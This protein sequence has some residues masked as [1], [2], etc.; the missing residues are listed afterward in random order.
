M[1]YP[2]THNQTFL[3][4]VMAKHNSS[5][6][7][8]SFPDDIDRKHFGSWLSGFVDG[9]GCFRLIYETNNRNPRPLA[10][11]CLCQRNDDIPVLQLIQAYLRCGKIYTEYR[12]KNK[13]GNPKAIFRVIRFSDLAEIVV[14]HF[15][16]YPLIAKKRRDF[17]IWREG[18]L[19]GQRVSKRPFKTRRGI[20]KLGRQPK[21][22]PE[23]VEHF[24]RLH[25]AL[26][27][28]REYKAPDIKVEKKSNKI[29]FFG[30]LLD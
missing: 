22:L 16:I 20:G 9:E 11:F 6:V 30:T 28:Q 3:G 10:E 12:Y 13:V 15:D 21:W 5:V 4:N 19:L 24:T 18:I 2:S 26:R 25:D 17:S 27:A 8:P 1:V 23:E 14:P 7:L 29:N